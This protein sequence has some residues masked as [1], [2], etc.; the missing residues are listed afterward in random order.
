MFIGLS[1]VDVS[2]TTAII[3]SSS[4]LEWQWEEFGV[5]LHIMDN[6]LPS[7]IDQCLIN[8]NASLSGHYK[9]S[10]SD[11][12]VSAIIWFRCD[13]PC[14]LAKPITLELQHCACSSNTS[15]LSFVKAMC[16][17]KD[18]PYTFKRCSGG[19]FSENSS[20]GVVDLY[21]FSALGIIQEGSEERS[22]LAALRY[23]EEHIQQ[24]ESTVLCFHLYFFITWNTDAHQKVVFDFTSNNVEVVLQY[25][26]HRL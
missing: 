26:L 12:L 11:N 25:C 9:F 21:S 16:N 15:K 13:P 2:G 19:Y 3:I 10:D 18:L 1:G 8:I 24:F 6:T 22:Y 7:G 5:K 17:Q 23:K 20:F 4:S 14:K